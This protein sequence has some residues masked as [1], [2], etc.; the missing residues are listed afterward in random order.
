M[1]DFIRLE[2]GTVIY[3]ANRNN[4]SGI[5]ISSI[6]PTE[7][8]I[9]MIGDEDP[10]TFHFPSTEARNE[11]LTEILREAPDRITDCPQEESVE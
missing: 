8:N 7:I 6:K 1:S 2:K 9:L 11:K 4:I 3:Y 5:S 10:T